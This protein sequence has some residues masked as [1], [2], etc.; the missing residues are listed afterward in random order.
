MTI[1]GEDEKP[2]SHLDKSMKN[3]VTIEI[4]KIKKSQMNT[5]QILDS[6]QGVHQVFNFG[7]EAK[8]RPQVSCLSRYSLYGLHG[9]AY[10]LRNHS[11]F[12]HY[13]PGKTGGSCCVKNHCPLQLIHYVSASVGR[14]TGFTPT[15]SFCARLNAPINV[16]RCGSFISHLQSSPF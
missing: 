9:N 2:P 15:I 16:F 11:L 1:T 3:I 4:I 8:E 12:Q 10:L 6:S 5:V 13:S 14:S 7:G